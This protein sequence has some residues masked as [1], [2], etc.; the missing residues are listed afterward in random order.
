MA[1]LDFL[2]GGVGNDTLRAN[3]ST[4]SPRRLRRCQGRVIVN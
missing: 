3:S 2:A 4:T 1:G